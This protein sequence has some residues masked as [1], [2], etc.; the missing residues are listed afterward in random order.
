METVQLTVIMQHLQLP[1][2]MKLKKKE[3]KM[4]QCRG[5]WP[6]GSCFWH[7]VSFVSMCFIFNKSEVTKQMYQHFP[8]KCTR[9]R[10]GNTRP[11]IGNIP[12]HFR[13]R[14][15]VWTRHGHNSMSHNHG[16]NSCVWACSSLF[17]KCS[18]SVVT[19]FFPLVFFCLFTFFFL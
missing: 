3:R 15:R 7:R 12:G 14:L 11:H 5:T 8:W 2:A 9:S 16:N 1:I 13:V 6:P 4:E 18:S 10:G 19:F 17:A